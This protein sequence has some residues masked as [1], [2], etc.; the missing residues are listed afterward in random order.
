MPVNPHLEA[1]SNRSWRLPSHA[2]APKPSGQR[3]SALHGVLMHIKNAVSALKHAFQGTRESTAPV[4]LTYFRQDG[5]NAVGARADQSTAIAPEPERDRRISFVAESKPNSTRGSLP[6]LSLDA[7]AAPARDTKAASF[8]DL[9]ARALQDPDSP[10][11]EEMARAFVAAEKDWKKGAA[12][13]RRSTDAHD[14]FCSSFRK[15]EIE[16]VPQYQTLLSAIGDA[17]NEG[18]RLLASQYEDML[19][20]LEERH[21]PKI[22]AALYAS[23]QRQML[24][25]AV[26]RAEA[27]RATSR[28][29]M[30]DARARLTAHWTDCGEMLES[31]EA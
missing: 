31:G 4:V 26:D 5:K 30:D 18:A 19:M 23:R 12:L 8:A 25:D 13:F 6:S 14:E 3:E 29:K 10:A 28:E 24:R 11:E 15:A 16:K 27:A 21:A 2:A 1:H 7:P 22:E 20:L 17:R 9:L